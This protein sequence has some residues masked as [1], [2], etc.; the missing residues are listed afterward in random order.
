MRGKIKSPL[1][2]AIFAVK[3]IRKFLEGKRLRQVEV[4]LHPVVADEFAKDKEIIRQVE[5][6][7]R[8]RVIITPNA[9]LKIEDIAIA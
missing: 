4:S 9:A 5:R 8:V 1:T 6:K 3:E 7:Y 2:M